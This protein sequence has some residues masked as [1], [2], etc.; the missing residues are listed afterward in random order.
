MITQA[1]KFGA[2][3]AVATAVHIASGSALI[4]AG[5][6]ATTANLL[7][8]LLA[9]G[10]S[11]AGHIDYTFRGRTRSRRRAFHRFIT[12]ALV[13]FLFNQSVLITLLKITSLSADVCLVFSTGI[14]AAFSFVL[15]RYW[16]FS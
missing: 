9:V 7:A 2:V 12:V 14:A 5:V 16:V 1:A 6:G 8:F 4:V 3:G 11:F 15:S 10:V 13:S